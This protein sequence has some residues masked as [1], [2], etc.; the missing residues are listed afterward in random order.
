MTELR[1]RTKSVST[2]YTLPDPTVDV[3]DFIHYSWMP[4]EEVEHGFSG[5]R[6]GDHWITEE[7]LKRILDGSWEQF[8]RQCR[9]K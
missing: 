9:R 4:L 5:E 6:I 2:E 8:Y 1:D 3:E 7:G